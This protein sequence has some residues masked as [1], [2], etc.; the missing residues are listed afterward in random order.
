MGGD[1]AMVEADFNA[2]FKRFVQYPDGYDPFQHGGSAGTAG[3][4]K[5]P[6]SGL[7]GINTK[8]PGWAPVRQ[9]EGECVI[10]V[11]GLPGEIG[12][13]RTW[14]DVMEF[15]THNPFGDWRW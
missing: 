14:H 4:L 1:N 6:K 3:Y 11:Q 7:D 9:Q 5:T 8:K 13:A 12:I 2:F 10:A 15:H